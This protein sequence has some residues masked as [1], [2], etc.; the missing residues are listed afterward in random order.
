M[1]F[2]SAV[3]FDAALCATSHSFTNHTWTSEVSLSEQKS[4][5][6]SPWSTFSIY[7]MAAHVVVIIYWLKRGIC[8]P[9]GLFR[10]NGY[11]SGRRN[12]PRSKATKQTEHKLIP[13]TSLRHP[14]FKHSCRLLNAPPPTATFCNL[15]Q[16]LSLYKA[17]DP[18]RSAASSSLASVIDGW[19]RA[20]SGLTKF[21]VFPH[22]SRVNI[23]CNQRLLGPR[24]GQPLYR[25]KSVH[26]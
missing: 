13:K 19:C 6:R 5:S 23:L 18:N 8:I 9:S 7:W 26:G 3:F 25:K 20:C 21:L 10:D 14:H 4:G 16:I 15:T 17:S 2:I 12:A 11:Y 1:L 24:E 22:F